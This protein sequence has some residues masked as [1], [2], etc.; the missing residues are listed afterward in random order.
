MNTETSESPFPTSSS[1]NG[2]G[3]GLNGGANA[4]TVQRMA[5][6]AHEA[7]DKLEQTIGSGSETVMGWQQ[8]YGEMAREQVKSNPLAAVGIAFGVGILFSKLFMR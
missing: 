1:A 7:V 6:K 4:G 5:Q 8:E 3:G 2:V